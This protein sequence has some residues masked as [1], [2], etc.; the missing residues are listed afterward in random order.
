MV[1]RFQG[2]Y[3]VSVDD[4]E[5]RARTAWLYFNSTLSI[6]YTLNGYWWLL[7][8]RVGLNFFQTG[9][10]RDVGSGVAG[11][12]VRSLQSLASDKGSVSEGDAIH[13]SRSLRRRNSTST[14]SEHLV[15]GV[16][17]GGGP[18]GQKKTRTNNKNNSSL[19]GGTTASG[20]TSPTSSHA[21]DAANILRQRQS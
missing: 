1:K 10:T 15:E 2:P 14:K 12:G 3:D 18:G 19:G 20:S 4:A 16:S 21:E 7:I 11:N 8:M 9:R 6:L 5:A 17:K 13:L